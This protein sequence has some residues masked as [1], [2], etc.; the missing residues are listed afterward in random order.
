MGK[1]FYILLLLL[2]WLCFGQNKK[3]DSLEQVLLLNIQDTNRVNA[4][5]SLTFY[6][7][8]K[9]KDRAL[10]LSGEAEQLAKKLDYRKGLAATY[11]SRAYVLQIAG[12]YSMAVDLVHQS[13]DLAE[14]DND[15]SRQAYCHGLLGIIYGR[16]TDYE[17]A[18]FHNLTSIELFEKIGDTLTLAAIN[19]NIGTLYEERGVYDSALVFY[20]K[21]LDYKRSTGNAWASVTELAN[22]G[23]AYNMLGEH[24][25]AL[26]YNWQGIEQSLK[27]PNRPLLDHFY[28]NRGQVFLDIG[29]LDSAEMY[30]QKAYEIAGG[31]KQPYHLL[32][33]LKLLG[34]ANRER[35]NTELATRYFHEGFS[36]AK[37]IENLDFQASVG[38]E[39]GGLYLDLGKTNDAVQV[40]ETA[41]QTG[42]ELKNY[43]HLTCTTEK[44]AMAYEQT[45]K[46]SLAIEFLKKNKTYQDSLSSI[47]KS[48]H[49]VEMERQYRTEKQVKELAEK[50]LAIS[51]RDARFRGFAI[52]GIITL[53]L[54]LGVFQYFRYRSKLQRQQTEMELQLQQSKTQQL[55]ELDRTKSNFFANISHE[56]R[57]PL[58][59]ISAPL[60]KAK[61]EFLTAN[62]VDFPQN[63]NDEIP[64]PAR[65]VSMMQR[66]TL[67]LQEL[68]DQ[69]LD[70][71][72]LESGNMKLQV[73]KG[74]VVKFV[75]AM[76]F[77]FESL[78]ERQQIDFQT[79]FP[80]TG[81]VAFFDK[82]KLE[83]IIV[84]LLSNAFKYTPKGGQI[85]VNT[86]LRNESVEVIIKDSGPGI[87]KND[88]DKIFERFYQI[89]GSE[90]KGTG[91]GLS[92]VKE[93]VELNR[94]QIEVESE[95]GKGTTFTVTLPINREAF[96]ADEVTFPPTGR[97][98][99]SGVR[100]SEWKEEEQVPKSL[101]DATSVTASANGF[102]MTSSLPPF[103]TQLAEKDFASKPLLLIVED[104]SDLRQFISETLRKDYQILEA[105]NGKV[106]LAVAIEKTPDL[107]ISDV[108]MPEMDGFDM[109]ETLKKDERTS[110]IPI[111]LLTA[112]AGQQHKVEGL[113]TGAD[114]YLTKPFDEKEL[115]VRAKNLVEQRQRLK[116]RFA[117]LLDF[118]NLT[119][120]KPNA[121]HVTSTDQRFL[122]KVS[123]VIEENIG[124]EF[125]SV[126]D[127]AAKV[128]FSRSQL[129]R[130]L[131]SLTGKSPN[132]MI[133][134][135]R[136]ARAKDL[137]NKKAGNVSEVAMEVGYSSVSYFTRSFK[138][139]FGMLPSEV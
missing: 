133:R 107:I 59:L 62:G 109:C 23:A 80:E 104:N 18:I 72:K 48:K 12:G 6:Y 70:L 53:M 32:P 121:V 87:S 77:S 88:L 14:T 22:I 108:M 73:A 96:K 13:I 26:D 110:H 115:L 67:R 124:N 7:K 100:E 74:D 43:V 20:F 125:F 79:T 45:S 65:H 47:E 126:E 113:E 94:G 97:T 35:G 76:V 16:W 50:E 118:K 119:D 24:E 93:L 17:K 71:S 123:T 3:T 105:E 139:A 106:G 27:S 58:T 82:D 134:D 68:I 116:E 56:F 61:E 57:T 34:E 138:Q 131:K 42:V 46:Y 15:L 39:L 83:K 132:E 49:L 28:T 36:I 11:Y 90:D 127:L 5:N 2:P 52:G 114:A 1:H 9:K 86:I 40:L 64:I 25:L 54:L 98:G 30:A 55:E 75:R 4:L 95:Q 101:Q 51:Q 91:I 38:C 130:K 41:F 89:E 19:T 44:L 99:F 103:N 10:L 81:Q 31:K 102:E 66:N 128:A 63:N 84:N 117:N 85:S 29:K 92:L 78:A 112:K 21:S 69:L 122:E 135:F 37:D 33:T 8:Y 111:I 137:L 136:L 129:H 120:L 60:K